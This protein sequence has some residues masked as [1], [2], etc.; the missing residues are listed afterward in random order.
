M[1]EY[2]DAYLQENERVL[3]EMDSYMSEGAIALA[4]QM[5]NE[6]MIETELADEE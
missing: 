4:K 3:D 5:A 2:S 1:L 6:D